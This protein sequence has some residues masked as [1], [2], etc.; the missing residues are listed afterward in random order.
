MKI[1]QT[2][3]VFIRH[4]ETDMNKS[5]LY[6]G[7]LDPE[8]NETGKEQLKKTK[9]LLKYF[10][11]NIDIVFSSNLKRCVESMEILKINQKIKK[12][13]LE[14]FK[15]INF[16]I[17][18]G[19]TYEEIVSEFPEEAEKMNNNW[20]T[21]KVQGGESLEEVMRRVVTKLKEL[22]NKYKNKKLIIVTHAG[23]IKT[24]VSYYLYG[25]L[26]GYWKIR[27]DN[28]SMTKMCVLEDGFVYFDYVNRI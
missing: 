12:I 4:G 7:H 3:I 25:N 1:R 17:F 8:L 9:K 19:K 6:F 11:K 10:E 27:I 13:L 16:G 2:D 26:D 5:K 14:E 20:R 21:F 15:E 24:I 18:E 28:G 23:V 22:I